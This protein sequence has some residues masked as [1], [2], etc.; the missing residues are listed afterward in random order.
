MADGAAASPPKK[1]KKL[2][3]KPTALRKTSLPKLASSDDDDG[4]GGGGGDSKADAKDSNDDGLALFRRSKEMEP[5]ME[6]ER[7][8]RLKKKQQREE[9]K[10]KRA[11]VKLGKRPL[12]DEDE[13]GGD[14]APRDDDDNEPLPYHGSPV[15]EPPST[16]E[17]DSIPG[18]TSP[19]RPDKSMTPDK[20]SFSDLVTPPSSKRSR[21]EST[22]SAVPIPSFEEARAVDVESPSTR[23]LR[24]HQ[25]TG[26]PFKSSPRKAA[27][28]P[29]SSNSVIISIDSDSDSDA[30]FETPSK[31]PPSTDS[32]EVLDDSPALLP[33][34]DEDAE[35][36]EYVRKA[37]RQRERDLAMLRNG[38]GGSSPAVKDNVEIV[39]TSALAGSEPFGGRVLYDQELKIVRDSWIAK[40]RQKGVPLPSREM[41]DYIL[42]W[43][44]KRVYVRSTLLNLGIR[45]RHGRVWVDGNGKDGLTG[46]GNR[47]LM[48]MWTPELFQAMERDEELRRRREAGELPESEYGDDEEAG[49]P[50]P[51]VKIRVILEA[52]GLEEVKLTV[53]PETTVETLVTG[54]RA[55]R[56]VAPDKTL[57]IM[58]DGEWL[59]EHVTMEEAEVEDMNKFEVHFR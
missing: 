14:A 45:P 57:R 44:R 6:A 10:R 37:E 26:T 58:F 34:D 46:N 38:A 17:S 33:P 3:F 31:R 48:E 18:A 1:L 55:Q 50:A 39:V 24:S 59:E 41:D 12:V 53:R 19:H 47:V 2:P 29:Q 32:I 42:T 43:R 54:F 4:G 15:K 7:A 51:E 16:A 40:Q 27:A 20:E 5:I 11:S 56:D 36:E 9:E 8:R 30:V 21:I 25:K 23:I 13:D 49:E 28:A 52:R 35:F 22:P